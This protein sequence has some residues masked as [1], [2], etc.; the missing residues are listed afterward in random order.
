[1]RVIVLLKW[2]RV[3]ISLVPV[4][5]ELHKGK[6]D[7]ARNQPDENESLRSTLCFVRVIRILSSLVVKW[8]RNSTRRKLVDE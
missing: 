5:M 7:T 8:K 1:M 2:E 6:E 3:R 4:S